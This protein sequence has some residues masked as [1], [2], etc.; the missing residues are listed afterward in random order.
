MKQRAKSWLFKA[1]NLCIAFGGFLH[2]T[3]MSLLLFGEQKYPEEPKD[4]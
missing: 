1:C 2:W 4:R 3:K